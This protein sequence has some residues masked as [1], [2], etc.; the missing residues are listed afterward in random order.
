MKRPKPP[1]P[2]LVL[3]LAPADVP[4]PAIVEGLREKL[5]AV[6]STRGEYF[7]LAI[8]RAPDGTATLS[9]E[10]SLPDG[11]IPLALRVFADQFE[12]SVRTGR[13]PAG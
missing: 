4:V 11:K 13:K 5:E 3:D 7:F 9:W 10:S 8:L 12:A 1:A 2:R 6:R